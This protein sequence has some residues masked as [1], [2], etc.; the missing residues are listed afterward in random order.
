MDA[1]IVLYLRLILR[2]KRTF[3]ERIATLT[4]VES[5]RGSFPRKMWQN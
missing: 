4:K 5:F 2:I 3:T 1:A